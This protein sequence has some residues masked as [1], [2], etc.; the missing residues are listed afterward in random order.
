VLIEF[1][2]WRAVPL[3]LTPF[4]LLA[5]LMG[6]RLAPYRQH[7]EGMLLPERKVLD[8]VGLG[9][10][11]IALFGMLVGLSQ[12]RA[13]DGW[14]TTVIIAISLLASVALRH[15]LRQM[16][17]PLLSTNVFHHRGFVFTCAVAFAYGV[18]MFGSAYLIP[19]FI[20]QALQRSPVE[21]GAMMLPAGLL[22]AASSPFG[23]WLAD[24]LAAHRVI[25]AG[26]ALLAVA[27]I[28]LL[29]VH[30]DSPLSLLMTLLLVSRFGMALVLPSLNLSALKSLPR[31]LWTDG[32]TAINLIRQLGASLGV[33]AVAVFLQWRLERTQMV[34]ASTTTLATSA[35][36]ETFVLI[37]LIAAVGALVALTARK[38]D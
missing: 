35:F 30:A 37:S 21:A 9:L 32:S 22:L 2:G 12:W 25:A 29:A 16:K 15:H 6:H 1:C 27:F 11:G 36:H 26:M 28:G 18:G 17:Q 19:V 4:C 23:G 33:S 31:A 34:E 3:A 14:T 7:G 13:A 8:G 24:R 38:S 5:L 10:S 20:Q